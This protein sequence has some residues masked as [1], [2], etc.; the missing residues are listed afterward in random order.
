MD[1]NNFYQ[2][3]DN[4]FQTEGIQSA[5]K[6]I[7]KNMECAKNENNVP[8]IVSIS[9][10]LGGIYRVT[11]RFEEA[12][13]VYT[14]AIEAIKILGLENTEQH[15][16]TLLNLASVYSESK[17]YEEALR[18]YEQVSNIFRRFHLGKD[19]RMAAL[20]NNISHV[21]DNLNQE[22]NALASAE[23]SLDIIKQLT[24]HK[25]E[26][27]TTHTTLALRYIKR[28]RYEEAEANLQLAE[29]IFSDLPGDPNVHY[30]A[31]LNALG[32]FY[33]IKGKRN[34]ASE[35]FKQALDIIKVNYG[36]NSSYA[37]VK[38]NLDK[39]NNRRVTGLQIAENYYLEIGKKMIHENFSNYE[40]YMAIGLVGEGSECLGFDDE[41]SEDHDF[42]T[43][44]C[45]WLPTHIFE[46]I[47]AKLKKA[48]ENMPKN[49]I[50]KFSIETSEGK[51]R[52]GVFSVN[53]FYKKYVGCP[54]I[55]KNN[56]EWLLAPEINLSMATNGKIFQDNLGEF[57]QIRKQ[58]LNFYPRDVLLKKLVARM[59]QMSQYGQ[60]NYER[61]MKRG[62]SAA[63]YLSCSEFV[64]STGSIVYLLNRKYMPFYKWMFRGMET[65]EHLSEVK[66]MLENLI[67]IPDTQKNITDK[68]AVI[69]EICMKICEELNKQG[70]SKNSDIFLANH[71]Q[72]IMN[73]ISDPKIRNL[74]IMY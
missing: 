22:E 34:L 73:S 41:I 56:I 40:K 67:D 23:K 28:H 11:S 12:K 36:E 25:V 6:Y 63:A 60:Y 52:T 57:T 55:P 2:E 47:G 5:E 24:N 44:F 16:T 3:L 31:T 61:C 62:D 38:R 46:E 74:P 17:E 54:G 4:I 35:Y 69:E 30:A 42:N 19:Y 1:L 27:A 48:Y 15:G 29:K 68:V 65:L 20:Y 53:D 33:F 37:E 14:L 59:A 39:I 26:L 50:N 21:Y 72:E 18:L 51:G 66:T 7:L 58:L 10:E 70:I 49:P 64:K 9:N 43:G 45:I 32:E 8:A 71:C 13:S